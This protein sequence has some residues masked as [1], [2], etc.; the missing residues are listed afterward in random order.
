[1]AVVGWE[2]CLH[3]C[4]CR[5][6]A[7]VEENGRGVRFVNKR[8]KR[9]ALYRVDGCLIKEGVKCD[10][11]FSDRRGAGIFHRTKRV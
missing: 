4:D 10:F 8:E 9:V 2:S 5:K 7:V 1:M 6:L 3:Y 11:Y